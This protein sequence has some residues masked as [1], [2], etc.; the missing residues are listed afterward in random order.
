MTPLLFLLFLVFGTLV[1]FPA[2]VLI[3]FI[4]PLLIMV[5]TGIVGFFGAT[6]LS[7]FFFRGQLRPFWK[8]S[9][10]PFIRSFL[11]HQKAPGNLTEDEKRIVSAASATLPELT[12]DPQVFNAQNGS[13]SFSSNSVTNRLKPSGQIVKAEK[14]ARSNKKN[15]WR[16]VNSIDAT[17]YLTDE[18]RRGF[19]E[20]IRSIRETRRREKKLT[21]IDPMSDIEEQVKS[22]DDEESDH[23][24][25]AEDP[26]HRH[27]Q[28]EF[29]EVEEKNEHPEVEGEKEEANLSE[30]EN[31][32][33][34]SAATNISIAGSPTVA[35]PPVESLF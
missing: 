20:R 6:F 1:A 28:K 16:F 7:I 31:Q 30:E 8:N 4:S 3:F 23:F 15:W 29:A 17:V 21:K 12:S 33:E 14:D 18:E 10:L 19:D 25:D 34:E 11:R 35:I 13:F 9:C 2:A 24:D 27:E 32:L 22:E 26:H 5:A